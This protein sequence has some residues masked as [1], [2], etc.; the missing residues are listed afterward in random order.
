MASANPNLY[1]TLY[2]D[3]GL[4]ADTAQRGER[5]PFRSDHV[6]IL[7]PTCRR[8]TYLKEVWGE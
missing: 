7:C 3:L 6:R 2:R 4:I 1:L 5:G 8:E